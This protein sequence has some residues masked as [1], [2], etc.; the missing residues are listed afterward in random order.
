MRLTLSCLETTPLSQC[1]I[2]KKQ[3][4][5]HCKIGRQLAQKQLESSCIFQSFCFLIPSGKHSTGKQTL[6]RCISYWTWGYSIDMLVY[7]RVYVGLNNRFFF[8]DF[9]T[10]Q[11]KPTTIDLWPRPLSVQWSSLLPEAKKHTQGSR[12]NKERLGE[13][14]NFKIFKHKHLKFAW[15]AAS[16]CFFPVN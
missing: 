13:N 3:Q 7:H 1:R 8:F 2:S 10:E 4:C 5:K 6:W 16:L 14:W 9:F 12:R 11:K 15:L